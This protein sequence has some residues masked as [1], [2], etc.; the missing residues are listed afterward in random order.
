VPTSQASKPKRRNR[1]RSTRITV[2]DDAIFLKSI[3]ENIPDMIFVKDASDLRF[4]RLNKAG[5]EL[6]GLSL[7]QLM[8]KNDYDFFPKKEADF[9]TA[10]DRGVLK[11]RKLLDI[12]E[13]PIHTRRKGVRYLHTKKIPIL[14]A[15]GRPQYLLGISE[16]IT[17]KKIVKEALQKAYESLETRVQAR[18]AE[19]SRMNQE[20]RQMIAERKSAEMALRESEERYRRVLS[21]LVEGVVVIDATGKI[22]SANPGAERI[23]GAPARKLRGLS[24]L[25]PVWGVLREDGTP[26]PKEEFFTVKSLNTGESFSNVIIALRRPDGQLL[27]LN[28]NT[29][30]LFRPGEKMPYA[31]VASFFDITSR[32]HLEE[33]I[34]KLN[35]ELEHNVKLRTAELTLANEDLESFSY[36][37]SHDLRAPLRAIEGF[38]Q[39][40]LDDYQEKLD[41][42]GNRLLTAVRRNALR[43]AQLIDD[44]LAFSRIGRKNLTQQPVA[45]HALVESVVEELRSAEP[46]RLVNIVLKSLPDAEGDPAMIRQ[47]WTNLLSNGLKFTQRQS[48][49]HIEIGSSQE[50]GQVV[51]YVRDNGAGFDMQFADKL[52]GVFQRL[53]KLEEFDG[54]GVGLAIVHRIVRKHGGRV[55]AESRVEQGATFYFSLPSPPVS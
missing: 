4:I 34:Q 8:G 25:N 49:P 6:L 32:R 19:L 29:Q 22:L 37:I 30:P 20:L 21:A 7:K 35:A 9:F 53:H 47:V 40:L 42:E 12:P 2:Q 39:V 18:T 45:M 48:K 10:K 11:S 55:W 46:K 26:T 27:W 44:L 36:S 50:D 17:E 15:S 28:G 43:M 51:Y 14:D 13:E 54:T 24:I 41:A 23:L 3:L 38:S 1:V 31:V 5:L 33:E 16:D 52:F